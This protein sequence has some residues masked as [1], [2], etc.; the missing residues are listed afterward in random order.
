MYPKSVQRNSKTIIINGRMR[1]SSWA[2]PSTRVLCSGLWPSLWLRPLTLTAP[3]AVNML[4]AVLCSEEIVKN[5]MDISI[6]V[7]GCSGLR[8]SLGSAL[9]SCKSNTFIS[10]HRCICPI[11]LDEL[12]IGHSAPAGAVPQL[13]T[14]SLLLYIERFVEFSLK[15]TC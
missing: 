7:E 8:P 6:L 12:M 5:F 4:H 13:R 10:I 11:V 1:P 3:A 14:P 9:G 15:S 2:A